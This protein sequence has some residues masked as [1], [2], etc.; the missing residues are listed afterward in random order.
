MPNPSLSIDQLRDQARE[1]AGLLKLFS[2]P[3]RLL[4]G[5]ELMGHERS[6]TEIEKATGVAQ[7]NL[8]R[9]LARLRE[10]DLI[11]ARRESKQ[12]FYRLK[13]HRIEALMTA[14]CQAFAPDALEPHNDNINSGDTKDESTT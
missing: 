10:A 13:D 5:C 8:S 14:L 3:N 12:V 1:V 4:I 11:V 7:P 6:V 2:H 9:D